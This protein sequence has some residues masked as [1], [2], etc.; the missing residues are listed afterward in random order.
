MYFRKIFCLV[1]VAVS[2]INCND[3]VT[4]I[5]VEEN[6]LPVIVEH[7]STTKSSMSDCDLYRV[8]YK[9]LILEN[10]KL[11]KSDVTLLKSAQSIDTVTVD[12]YGF[13]GLEDWN[14]GRSQPY[15]RTFSSSD[16]TAIIC[17]VAGGVYLAYDKYLTQ[18]YSLPT[19]LAI[20]L[21]NNSEY[22]SKTTQIGWNPDNLNTRGFKASLSGSTVTMHTAVYM[23][24]NTVGGQQVLST[25]PAK[26]SN[27]VWKLKYIQINM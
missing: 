21:D 6:H 2:F 17:E 13:S 25:Y 1:F 4:S 9:N 5:N 7:M 12:I 27:V 15:K 22:P 24:E 26:Y 23:V 20:I 14:T 3:N 16:A 10:V 11:S 8:Q 19:P 18:T